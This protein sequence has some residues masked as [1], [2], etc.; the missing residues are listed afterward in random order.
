MW[1]NAR[2][3]TGILH[4]V[5]LRMTRI[6]QYI[7]III[8][9]AS[10]ALSPAGSL[11]QGTEGI[12][13]EPLDWRS[14][15]ELMEPLDLSPEQVAALEAPH[16]EYLVS[17]MAIRDGAIAE[18]MENVS[19]KF[20]RS[21]NSSEEIT[22]R[23][24]E[25]RSIAKRMAA[26]EGSFLDGLS[27]VLSQDQVQRISIVKDLRSRQRILE[28]PWPWPQWAPS[29][30]QLAIELRPLVQWDILDGTS[31]AAV[32]IA[33]TSN[34]ERRT[35]LARQLFDQRLKGYIKEVEI[36]AELGPIHFPFDEVGNKEVTPEALQAWEDENL[37]RHHEAYG[38]ALKSAS[39]IRIAFHEGVDS[40]VS[41]LPDRTGRDF[42]WIAWRRGYGI[43]DTFQVRRMV[44][45]WVEKIE[46]KGEDPAAFEELLSGHDSR[47]ARHARELMDIVDGEAGNQGGSFFFFKEETKNSPRSQVE[48]KLQDEQMRTA[49]EFHSLL[50]DDAPEDLRRVIAHYDGEDLDGNTGGDRFGVPAKQTSVS[51][52]ITGDASDMEDMEGMEEDGSS[53]MFFGSTDVGGSTGAGG[54]GAGLDF[55]ASAPD[56][57]KRGDI[58]LLAADLQMGEEGLD[59]VDVLF[60]TYQKETGA[61]LHQFEQKR[62]NHAM[63]MAPSKEGD[64]SKDMERFVSMNRDMQALQQDAVEKMR[65]LDEQFFDDLVLAVENSDDQVVLRWHRL[66]RQRTYAAAPTDP[67]STAMAMMGGVGNNG[68]KIDLMHEIGKINL[69]HEHRRAALI[70]MGD[71]HEKTT[72]VARALADLQLEESE[73]MTVMISSS[74][75][76]Q[77]IDMEVAMESMKKM[78]DISKRRNALRDEQLQRNE[79]S[80]RA[81]CDVLP[82]EMVAQMNL[83]W[84]EA[85]YPAVY[86]DPR[87]VGD[88]LLAAMEL[89]GLDESVRADLLVLQQS[90][91]EQYKEQ[92]IGLV[93]IFESMPPPPGMGSFNLTK[94][95]ERDK[96]MNQAERIRFERDDLSDKTRDRLR[97]MLSEEQ[98]ETIGGLDVPK[99]TTMHWPKF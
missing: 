67:M 31:R 35:R 49:R 65:T 38:T 69:S 83:A 11:G 25:Y 45:K 57:M 32:E 22:E 88:K 63:S 87:G 60:E 5:A 17:M 37:R 89:D 26:V 93:D 79:A 75:D 33:L 81:I 47:T 73:S 9:F 96:A 78:Q 29:T 28:S 8:A 48:S 54:P 27:P 58:E 44:A 41:I 3:R 52:V 51:I 39:R 98:I 19:M 30:K 82:L 10:L 12:F 7:L 21:N 55:L 53:F 24:S 61:I 94:M 18:F 95:E 86:I 99:N 4:K 6:H 40:I 62:M 64:P 68:W 85:S 2:S 84:A 92:C 59:I 66:A 76:P 34:E 42:Q 71:W 90:Y 46:R 97:A 50:G 91:S 72:D 1:D 36:E 13:S 43:Q 20:A 23:V 74:K 15:Q 56:A 77:D 14:F 80:L 70:A 16:E